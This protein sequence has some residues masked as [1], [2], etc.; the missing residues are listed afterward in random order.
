MGLI[1]SVKSSRHERPADTSSKRLLLVPPLGCSPSSGGAPHG[2]IL[3]RP[4]LRNDP[5]FLI[6]AP[7][8]LT[9]P[10]ASP[11]LR[12]TS[13]LIQKVLRL[14][15]SHSDHLER[16]AQRRTD[17]DTGRVSLSIR[18]QFRRRST[19]HRTKRQR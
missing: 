2:V 3:A 4:T 12:A 15:G 8:S 10:T 6:K 1:S 13:G 18:F 9:H 7:A 17:D 11:L 16:F 19:S 14:H 5:R